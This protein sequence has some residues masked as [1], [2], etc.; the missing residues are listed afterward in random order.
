MSFR[1]SLLRTSLFATTVAGVAIA[2][3]ASAAA[4][5]PQA[6]PAVGYSA[7]RITRGGPPRGR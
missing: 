4:P 6:V 2:V 5:V 1:H 7:S 3:G